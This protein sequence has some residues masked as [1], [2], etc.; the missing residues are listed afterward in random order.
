MSGFAEELSAAL[1]ELRLLAESLMFDTVR[2]ERGA[3]QIDDGRGGS[4]TAFELVYEGRAKIQTPENYEKDPVAG[5]HTFVL[6]RYAVH[7]PWDAGPFQVG[8]RIT[9]TAAQLSAHAVGAIYRVTGLHEKTMQ[10]A[11]R[12]SIEE[13]VA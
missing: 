12:V 13:V 6:Q 9:V 5:G 4:V 1:P 3:G 2:V 8:D 10:T 11:Q 7:M